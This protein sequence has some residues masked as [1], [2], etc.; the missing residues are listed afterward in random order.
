KPGGTLQSGPTYVLGLGSPVVGDF[1]G[2]G[3]PDLVGTV[4]NTIEP[5]LAN[6]NGSLP[7][8]HLIPAAGVTLASTASADFN[9]DGI[10]D[11]VTAKNGQGA[12]GPRRRAVRG[13]NART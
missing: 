6:A 10:P 11:L 13:P 9:G 12:L 1:N 2:D 3:H 8:P 5:W 7:A 4:G